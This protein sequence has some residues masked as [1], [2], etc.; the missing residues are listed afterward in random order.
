M[1]LTR[2]MLTAMGIEQDKIEQIIEG[3]AESVGAL[4]DKID[5]LTKT[6]KMHSRKLI[7]CQTFRRSCT[8]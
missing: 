2:K 6:S 3:N 5:K 1:A 4:Q 8:N 7:S